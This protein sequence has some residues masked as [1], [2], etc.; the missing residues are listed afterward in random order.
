MVKN[1]QV[2]HAVHLLS[3]R[4]HPDKTHTPVFSEVY[5]EADRKARPFIKPKTPARGTT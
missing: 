3:L 2:K 4:A 5:F 1:I